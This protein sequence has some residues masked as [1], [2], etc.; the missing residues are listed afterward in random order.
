MV[1]EEDAFVIYTSPS[2]FSSV[3]KYLEEKGVGFLEASI[4]MVPQNKITLDEET[5]EKFLKLIDKLDELDDVQN[6]YHN[7]N[8]PDEEE[9]E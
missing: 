6:I 4:E 8:L 3:R 7:V 9:E 5:T 2:D 1:T